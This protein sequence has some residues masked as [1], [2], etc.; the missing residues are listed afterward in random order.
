VQWQGPSQMHRTGIHQGLAP[1]LPKPRWRFW[2]P[3]LGAGGTRQRGPAGSPDQPGFGDNM[4]DVAV[5]DGDKVEAQP[6]FGAIPNLNLN[7][8]RTG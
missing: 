7:T 2:V 6:R 1:P 4:R 3:T 5:T 8:W